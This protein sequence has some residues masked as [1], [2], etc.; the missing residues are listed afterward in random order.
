MARPHQMV[1]M[2]LNPARPLCSNKQLFIEAD[3]ATVLV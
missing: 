2:L 3:H 1:I